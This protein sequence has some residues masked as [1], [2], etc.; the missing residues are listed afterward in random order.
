MTR[1]HD[2][3]LLRSGKAAGTHLPRHGRSP[4]TLSSTEKPDADTASRVVPPWETLGKA[5]LTHGDRKRVSG[6]PGLGWVGD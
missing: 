2:G 4:D 5:R 6:G 1:P 3:M